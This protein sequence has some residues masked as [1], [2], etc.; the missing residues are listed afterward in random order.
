MRGRGPFDRG[1]FASFEQASAHEVRETQDSM[2]DLVCSGGQTQQCVSYHRSVDLQFDRVLIVAEELPEL[3]MLLDPSKQ[4]FD[5]PTAFI[6]SADFDGL[7]PHII[8]DEAE[9][10]AFSRRIVTRRSG[11]DSLESPLLDK[12]TSSSASTRKPSPCDS[13]SGRVAVTRRPMLPLGRV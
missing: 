7:P 13:A 3:E 9:N 5:L 10:L 2:R 4:Q 8:G 6:K 12:A 11:I 1:D